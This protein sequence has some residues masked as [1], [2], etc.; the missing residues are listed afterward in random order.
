MDIH[1]LNYIIAIAEEKNM[2]RAA[3]RLYVSQSS[4]SHYLA[5]LEQELGTALFFRG[6]N[7][8]IPTP[9]G[10]MYLDAARRV[11]EIQQTLYKNIRSLDR[12]GH[13]RIS[14]T[15]QWGLE[16]ITSITS[17]FKEAFPE[18]TFELFQA[19]A[20]NLKKM[21]E[22]E[23]IDFALMSVGSREELAENYELLQEEELFF[24]VPASHPYSRQNPGP[25]LSEEDLIRTFSG[26]HLLLSKKGTANR[27]LA[28]KIFSRCP[29]GLS[30]VSEV[31][32]MTM[33]RE[34]VAQGVGAAFIPASCR[35]EDARIHY[36]ALRPRLVRYNVLVHRKNLV[37]NQPEQ[38]FH[39]CVVN[40]YS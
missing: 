10:E 34:L 40:Y 20:D 11:V 21:L 32:G 37:L 27:T 30:S 3:Q 19:N 25:E 5:K 18:V 14:T 2:T 35:K 9:A 6:K 12:R 38:F 4:L 17:R 15:S 28:D 16:M 22:T 36:Y 8:L 33:T 29:L 23:A 13:L 31:N 39:S 26:A 7:E 1:Y 24:A